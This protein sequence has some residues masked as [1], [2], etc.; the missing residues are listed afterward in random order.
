MNTREQDIQLPHGPEF[1]FI[2][3]IVEMEPGRN[4]KAI[5]KVRGD[6]PFLRGHFPGKPMM[7][8][9]LLIEAVAQL[10]GCVGQAG[11]EKPLANLKLAA[12]RNAKISGTAMPGQIIELV[13][14]ITGQMANVMQATGAAL[15]EG[16]MILQ[17]EVALAG[18]LAG[19]VEK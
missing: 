17:V 18:D 6:E 11:L 16:R 9:V 2:D 7:P 3:R 13:V 5:Y 8:G 19:S 14:T 15:V 4:G 1:R 10:A 12:V